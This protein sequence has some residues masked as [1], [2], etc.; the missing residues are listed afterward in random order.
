MLSPGEA[1]CLNNVLATGCDLCCAAYG[2]FDKMPNMFADEYADMHFLHDFSN[3]NGAIPAT[4]ST[5]QNWKLRNIC[6]RVKNSQNLLI[7]FTDNAQLAQYVTTN[8]WN[9]QFCAQKANMR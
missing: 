4:T 6:K 2:G 5:S 9:S 1:S 7:K 3:G 8:T